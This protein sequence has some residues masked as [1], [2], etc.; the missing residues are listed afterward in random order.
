VNERVIVIHNPDWHV[1]AMGFGA[2]DAAIVVNARGVV[3]ATRLAHAAGVQIGMRRR[4]AQQRCP[5]AAV[6][7]LDEAL[8]LRVY[9]AV[10]AAVEPL[11]T[12]VEVRAAGELVCGARGPSKYYGG[13]FACGEVLAA[14]VDHAVERQLEAIRAEVVATTSAATSATQA[15]PASTPAPRCGV[16]V[17][18]T[19]FAAT[20]AARLNLGAVR[21]IARGTT[22][23][24][25]A[26]LPVE[27]IED[28]ELADVLVRLGLHTL[29]SF[30]CVGERD[31]AARFGPHG[32][33]A[34]RNASG[35]DAH[36]VHPRP[37]T[38]DMVVTRELDPPAHRVDEVAFVAKMAADQ[39]WESMRKQAMTCARLCVEAETEHGEQHSRWWRH[40]G[41]LTP[42]A[43]AER[44]RL[45]LES[46]V[47]S[48]AT[49]GGVTVVRLFPD[50]LRA[51]RGDQEGL[52]GERG[53]DERLQKAVARLQG[54]LGI[55]EVRVP[56][57]AGGRH[58][59]ERSSSVA[60]GDAAHAQLPFDQPWPGACRGPAPSTILR[61]PLPTQVGDATGAV[62]GVNG[63]GLPTSTPAW[64][65]L[66]GR[67]QPLRGWAG[68]WPVEERWWD[69]TRSRRVARWQLVTAD[70]RAMLVTLESGAWWI[71]GFYD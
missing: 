5:D 41:R 36:A 40:D 55:D 42:G 53:P 46:W 45:Q 11:V 6:V 56:V 63:R 57:A 59:H 38:P 71:E 18:D 66:E 17:A 58:H 13:D 9:D 10:V 43:L 60:W 20:V 29:G 21:V 52:W 65:L 19:L 70:E 30:A 39:L 27:F 23:Q 61:P 50:E 64:V 26:P 35:L 34:W 24:Y 54:L 51:D 32:R 47:R 3:S 33:T 7:T 44:V 8:S 48:G 1:T 68:P 14:A 62:V 4:A 31:V 67:R 69:E 2:N 22:A 37:P 16:G 28:P 25:L 12:T 49:S 15:A